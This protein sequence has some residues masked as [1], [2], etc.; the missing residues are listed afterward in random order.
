MAQQGAILISHHPLQ[1]IELKGATNDV[2]VKVC[3]NAANAKPQILNVNKS[4]FL[5]GLLCAI[6]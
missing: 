3:E 4:R 5:P 1:G 6:L 2:I